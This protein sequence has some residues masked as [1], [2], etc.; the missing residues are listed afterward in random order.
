MPNYN[1]L[2]ASL[3]RVQ[4]IFR[5]CVDWWLSQSVMLLHLAGSVAEP[6]F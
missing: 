3:D 2:R 5:L 6:Q 1:E 4:L